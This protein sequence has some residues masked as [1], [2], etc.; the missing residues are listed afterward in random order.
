MNNEEL[1]RE[2]FR[3]LLRPGGFAL[4]NAL[5]PYD[6]SLVFSLSERLRTDGVDPALAAAVLTQSRLRSAARAKF[7]DFAATMLFT[8]T[9]LQQ[10]T[11]LEV[12]A[13][14]AHRYKAAGVTTVA[15]LGCGI[16]ADSLAFAGLG[17]AVRAIE[18]DE[19]TAAAA[20]VNLASFPD[21]EVIHGDALTTDLTGCDGV[22]ADPARRTAR[23]TRVFNPNHY[24]PRLDVVLA[25]HEA[26]P[27]LGVK[28]APGIARN[29]IPEDAEAQWVS[30]NGDVVEAGL[31]FGPLKERAGRSALVLRDG[32]PLAI[33]EADM[34][35]DRIHVGDLGHYIW[36]PD[37]AVIRSGL[38]A[39]VADRLHGHLVDSSIAYV[40]T[41]AETTSPLGIGYRVLDAFPFSLKPLRSYLRERSVGRITI[42]KRGTAVVP[43]QLRK[44]LSLRGDEAAT[45]ILTRLAGKQSVIVVDPL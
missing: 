45:I 35:S 36:E 32:K 18:A 44:Q 17:L 13:F 33:S 14:H 37:G 22:Y 40:T 24:Q 8:P 6:E 2:G 42:K 39:V 15:D 3:A 19:I 26:I 21:V 27:A 30:V 31:W 38:V 25:L 7:G 16:G 29:A 43:E 9:G 10:A 23:G 11:R 5:G 1:N 4:L 41:D 20:T 28:V 34:P 12:A